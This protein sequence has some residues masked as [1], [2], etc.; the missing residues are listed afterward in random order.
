M[1]DVNSGHYQDRLTASDH[2]TFQGG[3]LSTIGVS[4]LLL[5]ASLLLAGCGATCDRIEKD[6]T[7]FLERAGT[8]TDTHI[9]VNVPFAVA[10]RLVEPHILKVQPIDIEL[11]GLGRIA[12]Y[13]GQ[14]SIMPTKV[15]LEAGGQDK[16]GF[17][18][19]FDIRRNGKR[20][21]SMFMESEMH[22]K[23]DIPAGKVI[24]GFTPEVL[25]N[26]RPG[27][28]PDAKRDLTDAIYAQ[29]PGPVR[30]LISRSSVEGVVDSAINGL[31]SK[32]YTRTKE[33]MLPKMSEMSQ[34]EIA[35]PNMPLTDVK[36]SS[37]TA[38][39][40]AV[41]LDIITAL[42]VKTGVA[43]EGR[44][45]LSK[46]NITFRTSGSVA[47]ELVNMA[48]AK[49]KLPD[50]YDSKGKA[51]ENGELRA[52][53]DWIAG[54]ERPMKIYL[55]DLE[56]PCMRFTMSAMPTIAVVG[57][58]V[59]IKAEKVETDDVQAAAFTK[60]GVWFHLLWK[61][62]LSVNK[63]SSA[64]IKT[65][66]AGDETEVLVKKASIEKDELVLEIEL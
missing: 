13:F 14:I 48:M 34:I 28:S 47:A 33:R 1:N 10:N 29:I 59:E 46:S 3:H 11:P 2:R 56:K 23:V 60:V 51:K 30:L 43:P 21:F 41:R 63:K 38:N 32:F 49:G 22:P 64:R 5:I 37:T 53:L 9:M 8:N 39:G 12:S 24:I 17:H 44:A 65:T 61:D 58:N 7:A 26:A 52:G 42:P 40:G 4:A 35:L 31:I 45:P 57:E 55:W 25:E 50:R 66:V 20:V 36:I 15:T 19:D 54:D 27:I 6:R 16:I 18:L 62:A